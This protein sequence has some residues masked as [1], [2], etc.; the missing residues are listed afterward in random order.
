[1]GLGN[2]AADAA[3]HEAATRPADQPQPGVTLARDH[4]LV[5]HA[6]ESGDELRSAERTHATAHAGA[7][8]VDDHA[9]ASV[10]LRRLTADRWTGELD[11]RAVVNS[12]DEHPLASTLTAGRS[13]RALRAAW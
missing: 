13:A 8:E 10:S 2:Q 11:L 7:T 9:V 3:R 6:D 12:G 5:C 1:M 4:D